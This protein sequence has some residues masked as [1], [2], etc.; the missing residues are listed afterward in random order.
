MEENFPGD[1]THLKNILQDPVRGEFSGGEFSCVRYGL[2][3]TVSSLPIEYFIYTVHAKLYTMNLF[4]IAHVRSYTN[5]N[6]FFNIYICSLIMLF[7]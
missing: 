4:I 2:H 3:F 1:P 5:F 7:Y 6:C